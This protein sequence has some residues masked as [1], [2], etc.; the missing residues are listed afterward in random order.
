MRQHPERQALPE[1][2][3]NRPRCQQRERAP[4]HAPVGE[5]LA[6]PGCVPGQQRVEHLGMQQ[7]QEQRNDRRRRV[8]VGP[9]L[10][11][12]AIGEEREAGEGDQD[13]GQQEDH[14]FQ[15]LAGRTDRAAHAVGL[16]EVDAPDDLPD[17]AGQVARQLARRPDA[18]GG[19]Q[20]QAI[21]E[22]GEDRAPG[23]DAEDEEERREHERRQGEQSP[24]D[25]SDALADLVP[26]LQHWAEH[27]GED[28][29][30]DRQADQ[31][32]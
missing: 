27:P 17:D 23:G 9:G 30:R 6:A 3:E 31:P 21:S 5:L 24:V 11:V 26:L 15:D 13:V 14:Q 25:G 19:G 8:H 10:A 2:P 22:A 20:R 1:Q 16:A 12:H 7:E 29:D 32:A 4:A 28:G 18:R